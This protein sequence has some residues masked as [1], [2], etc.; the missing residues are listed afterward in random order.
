MT[1]IISK[2]F[3][4]PVPGTAPISRGTIHSSPAPSRTC[5][6]TAPV[7]PLTDLADQSWLHQPSRSELLDTIAQRNEVITALAVFLA[8]ALICLFAF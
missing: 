5:K 6:R 7:T 1:F 2:G 8:F 4:R 3:L